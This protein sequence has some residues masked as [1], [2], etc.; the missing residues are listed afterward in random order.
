MNNINNKTLLFP[1]L[2]VLCVSWLALL[3]MTAGNAQTLPEQLLP[4]LE[5]PVNP[6]LEISSSEGDIYVELF[7]DAA[8][9]NVRRILE[10]ANGQLMPQ[11]NERR[12]YDGLTFHRVVPGTFLQTGAAERA[13]RERPPAIA[14]EINARG[15]GLEQQPLL[16]SLGRPHPWMNIADTADFQNRVLVPFYRSLDIRSTEQAIA[17]QERITAR[18]GTMNIMQVHELAGY[19]YNA[20]LPSRRPLAGSLLMANTGPGTNDAGLIITLIDTPWLMATHTVIGRVVSG[21]SLANS[22]S[23]QP[24]GSVSIY[25]IRTV[26]TSTVNLPLQT[27]TEGATNESIQP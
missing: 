15:L 25:H 9:L 14:D 12:Y 18:L 5:N 26:D 17:Q 6:L 1:R 23:R 8:P 10:L 13:G 7:P 2:H 21:L 22:I 11:G 19:R 24:E 27:I 4:L 3:L 20:S 16:D